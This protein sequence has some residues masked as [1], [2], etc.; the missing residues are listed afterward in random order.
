MIH[1][2]HDCLVFSTADGEEIPCSVRQVTVEF[3]GDSIGLVDEE[4]IEQ[5]AEAVLHYFKTDLG[6]TTVTVA[7][8]YLA[9]ERALRGLGLK[10][11]AT[12]TDP[13]S[14]RTSDMDLRHFLSASDPTCELLFFSTLR[15]AL[16]HR[17]SDSH[18]VLRFN[19][20]RGCVKRINGTKRWSP[21]CQSLSDQI[22]DYLRHCLSLECHGTTCALVVV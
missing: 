20:L 10:V 17:L 22:V 15:E 19:G 12:E 21:R 8:F 3:M 9:L 2:R 1:L 18:R 7:E 13:A 5:A 4:V 14:P 16:R 11:S 6:R